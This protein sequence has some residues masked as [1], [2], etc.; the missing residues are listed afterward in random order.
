MNNVPLLSDP[1]A[2][3]G[4]VAVVTGGTDG[5]GRHLAQSLVSLG[6]EVFFCG[7][8]EALGKELEA[9]WGANAHYFRCDLSDPEQTREFIHHA[10]ALRGSIDFL[11][12]NAAIDPVV[13]FEDSSLEQF[14]FLLAVNLRSYFLTTQTALPYLR[15]GEGKAV[16]NIGSTNWMIGNR[17]Y[18]MYAATKSGIVGLT[19]SL[20]RDLGPE[21]IRVNLVSLGWI[22][23]ARQLREKVDEAT[24]AKLVESTSLGF[25]LEERHVV[26][27]ILFLLSS[28]A[29]GVAG[30]NLVVD[31][32]LYFH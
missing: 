14:D 28:A 2:F 24:K 8:R 1:A 20:T 17:N 4:R 10:G 32:G 29:A 16:V 23:T 26:P 18:A 15:K 31:G 19:R 27:P 5:I 9:E 6:C 11:V 7:R 25:A 21:G 30:Q 13:P 12:N 22:M 3:R